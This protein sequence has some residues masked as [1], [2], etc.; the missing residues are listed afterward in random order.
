MDQSANRNFRYSNRQKQ[1]YVVGDKAYARDCTIRI[2]RVNTNAVKERIIIEEVETISGLNT[3]LAV[4]QHDA[5]SYDVTMDCKVNALKL[6]S[7]ISIG[8]RDYSV[9]LMYSDITVVS[10][11]KL[12][13]YIPDEDIKIKLAVKGVNVVSPIYRR[14][15]PGTQVADGTRFMRCRFPPNVVA[16][17][18]TMPFKIGSEIK[19]FRVVHNNQAK[20]CSECLS[21]DHMKKDCPYF[22]CHGCG[23]SGHPMKYCKAD[24]CSSCRNLPLKCVCRRGSSG[25]KNYSPDTA[26]NC[27]ECGLFFCGCTCRGCGKNEC[28][29]E[30]LRCKRLLYIC[31]NSCTGGGNDDD[32]DSE[33]VFQNRNDE[34]ESNAAI[35]VDQTEAKCVDDPDL[36]EEIVVVEVHATRN[37]L[38]E[39]SRK[40]KL[41][42]NEQF[43]DDNVVEQVLDTSKQTDNDSE[44]SI[45]RKRNTECPSD[46]IEVIEESNVEMTPEEHSIDIDDESSTFNDD[47]G[48]NVEG[49]TSNKESFVCSDVEDD[50]DSKINGNKVDK[51]ISGKMAKKIKKKE[52]KKERRKKIKVVPNLNSKTVRN[53]SE[54]IQN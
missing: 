54:S 29:C 49:A 35:D 26:N 15:V 48:V 27:K 41:D 32:R 43:S 2:E 9:S 34:D 12:P 45:K 33:F 8:S 37:G 23:E 51:C 5:S 47:D 46:V 50:K 31:L 10:I 20:V 36:N 44:E 25:K 19:Y 21:P 11:M 18:W 30:C 39:E 22:E 53:M 24:K 38:Q 7:G 16:L 17:P 4:V 1:N 42:S 14:T 3:V 52:K 40:R 6:L 13:S 28:T